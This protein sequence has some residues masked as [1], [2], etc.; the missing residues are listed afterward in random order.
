MSVAF[1]AASESL[2]RTTDLID[3]TG[4]F[5]ICFWYR[6]VAST[7]TGGNYRTALFLAENDYTNDYVWI[8]SSPDT[9]DLALWVRGTTSEENTAAFAVTLDADVYVSVVKSGTNISLYFDGVL[10]G[11]V[12]QDFSASSFTE[13]YLGDDNNASWS[14]AYVSYYRSWTVALSPTQLTTERLASSA[15]LTSDLY[16]DTRLTAHTNL[17]DVSGNGHDWT[18]VGTLALGDDPDGV[19]GGTLQYGG[20]I[21]IRSSFGRGGAN[22][23]SYGVVRVYSA[24][25]AKFL[26]IRIGT[27]SFPSS[28]PCSQAIHTIYAIY[29]SAGVEYNTAGDLVGDAGASA[30]PTQVVE[31]GPPVRIVN[32]DNDQI[33][34]VRFKLGSESS[35]G[36]VKA[37]DGYFEV[38][39]NGSVKLRVDNIA[40][41]TNGTAGWN[42]VDIGPQGVIDGDGS[43]GGVHY[44]YINGSDVYGA[45]SPL[46]EKSFSLETPAATWASLGGFWSRDNGDG[47]AFESPFLQDGRIIANVAMMSRVGFTPTPAVSE[48]EAPPPPPVSSFPGDAS[49]PCC[50]E[51]PG[52][53]DGAVGTTPEPDPFEPL[54]EWIRGCVGGGTVPS[55]AD[56]T[57]PEMW[58]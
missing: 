31:G 17:T 4:D 53:G 12:V 38:R 23:S 7:P 40:L 19:I 8:G 35:P 2:R 22:N 48:G 55:V 29:R 37:A 16:S 49:T 9:V 44:I 24:G 5:T 58:T 18:A 39:V 11:T 51:T 54:P 52:P 25:G 14:S 20:C 32:C 46:Y 42:R 36:Y 33:I 13:E 28:Y 3:G 27:N 41:G 57:D 1:D 45:S 21:G 47:G 26:W 6:P 34:E 56:P 43:N 15:V 10:K 50:A 30:L